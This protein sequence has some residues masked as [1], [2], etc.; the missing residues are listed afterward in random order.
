M[1]PSSIYIYIYCH[2]VCT[3]IHIRIQ[4][5]TLIGKSRIN[6]NLTVN[7]VLETRDVTIKGVIFPY[8]GFFFRTTYRTRRSHGFNFVAARNVL[9]LAPGNEARAENVIIL[10]RF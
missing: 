5:Y 4:Q 2:Y 8:S 10:V 3:R 7:Y 6:Q 1:V 9:N